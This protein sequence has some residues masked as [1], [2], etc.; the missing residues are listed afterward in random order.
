MIVLD[1][2]F[3]VAYHNERDVHHAA[4]TEVMGSLL[5]G[6]WGELLLPEYVFLEV[7]TV[8]AARLGLETAVGVGETLLNARELDFIPCS[9]LFLETFDLFRRQSTGA[10]S[11]TD[12]ATVA[13]A[14]RRQA[15]HVA[16]FDNDFRRVEGFAVV[17]GDGATC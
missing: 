7:V 3:L 4:A 16:T 2:S 14:R 1:S 13:I 10:L 17:P 5:N 15:R 8:L 12:A 6:S 11:F 9:E